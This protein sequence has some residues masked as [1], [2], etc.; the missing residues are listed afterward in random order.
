[1]LCTVSSAE[2]RSWSVCRRQ[3]AKCC[4]RTTRL[5]YMFE[6]RHKPQRVQGQSWGEHQTRTLAHTCVE[7]CRG[8]SIREHFLRSVLRYFD[9]SRTAATSALNAPR[10][11]TS[12]CVDCCAL[13]CRSSCRSSV[14]NPES[15]SGETERAGEKGDEDEKARLARMQA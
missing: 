12:V 10:F 1:M 4:C 11:S 13:L 6:K 3:A 5:P 15:E 2:Y 14:T 7:F 8:L 9:L